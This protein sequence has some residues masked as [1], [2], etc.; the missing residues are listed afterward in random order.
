MIEWISRVRAVVPRLARAARE[1]VEALSPAKI[2]AEALSVALP[3]Q[4]F[5]RT[6]TALLRAAGVR[7]GP[8]SLLQGPIRITGIGNRC[9]MLSMGKCT[10]ITG[11]LHID[12]G[13]PVR[14]GSFVRIGHDVTLLTI[15]HRIGPEMLRAGKTEFGPIEIGDGAWI[16]SRVTILPNVTIG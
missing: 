2:F 14:I 10:I 16:A 11:P 4:T 12:I 6:R 7:V 9:A 5:D 8:Q 3:Q 1:E 13:A 15:D